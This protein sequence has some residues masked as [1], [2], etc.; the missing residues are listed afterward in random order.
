MRYN[1][2][3]RSTMFGREWLIV[4]FQRDEGLTIDDLGERYV[5]GIAAIAVGS[6]E[7]GITVKLGVFEQGI[8]TYTLPF[9]VEMS[10]FGDAG[11]IN[12]IFLHGKFDEFLPGPRDF[13]FYQSVYAE[14]PFINRCVWGWAR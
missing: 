6:H 14:C 9:H 3:R 12:H 5:G 13:F 8:K 7:H 2:A 11:N 1:H 10:P 4:I